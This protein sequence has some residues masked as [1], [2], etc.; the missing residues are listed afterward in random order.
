[1]CRINVSENC[2]CNDLLHM[3]CSFF[4]HHDQDIVPDTKERDKVKLS[5][6]LQG[7]EVTLEN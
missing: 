1:M 5:M 3:D 7:M 4:E 2:H 6:I